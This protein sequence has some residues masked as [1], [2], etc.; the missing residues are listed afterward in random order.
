MSIFL[1]FTTQTLEWAAQGGGWVPIPGGAQNTCG[2]GT[3]G[4]GL[5]DMV[6]LGGWLDL[7]IL[8]DFS[9]LWF[10]D[11]P[12]TEFWGMPPLASHPPHARS[13]PAA[14]WDTPAVQPASQELSHEGLL[15]HMASLSPRCGVTLGSGSPALPWGWGSAPW[16]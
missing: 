13:R 6:G 3:S 10:Y 1:L 4:H 11:S 2:C 16:A 14:W 12:T 5:A 15:G 9:N 7:M 8:E